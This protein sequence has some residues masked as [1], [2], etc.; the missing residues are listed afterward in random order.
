MTPS[1]DDHSAGR[2]W[3]RALGLTAAIAL[4]I[5]L[6]FLVA[7][8]R[9]DTQ[10]VAVNLAAQKGP[11]PPGLK[12]FLQRA[13]ELQILDPTTELRRGDALRFVVRASAP[14][15]L[16]VRLRDGAG[17]ERVVFPRAGAR[18][19]AL[20]RPDA[21]LPDALPIDDASAGRQT[22]TA[23]FSQRPF[24]VDERAGAELEVATVDLPTMP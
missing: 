16:V 19:A 1:A 21:A 14:R 24:A 9:A 7:R 2:P 18:D 12:I 8:P 11:R 6:A 3:A 10:P 5:G 20:V 23:L 4:V 15:Y 13:G 17:H 22:L